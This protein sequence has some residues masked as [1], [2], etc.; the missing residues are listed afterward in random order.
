MRRRVRACTHHLSGLIGGGACEHAPYGCYR[1]ERTL[2]E[3][4]TFSMILPVT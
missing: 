2:G 3:G 4:S 1:V